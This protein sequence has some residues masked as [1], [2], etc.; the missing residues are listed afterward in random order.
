[1]RCLLTLRVRWISRALFPAFARMQQG[2]S[3]PVVVPGGRTA[4]GDR[5]SAHGQ[6]RQR[7]HASATHLHG[8]TVE[9]SDSAAYFVLEASSTSASPLCATLSSGS[10]R[11]KSPFARARL[12]TFGVVCS[13]PQAC[14]DVTVHSALILSLCARAN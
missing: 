13:R 9:G 10:A 2:R 1:M 12:R 4:A 3:R 8:V 11:G 6:R 14:L 7:P 5:A